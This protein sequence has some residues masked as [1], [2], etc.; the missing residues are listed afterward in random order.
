MRIE[1]PHCSA[2]VRLDEPPDDDT[3]IRCPECRK[4]FAPP[5][6]DDEDDDARPARKGARVAAPPVTRDPVQD[7]VIVGLDGR[8]PDRMRFLVDRPTAA[9]FDEVVPEHQPMPVRLACVV[10]RRGADGVVP[11]RVARLDFLGRADRVVRTIPAA[12]NPED[13]LAALNRDPAKF[14]GQSLEMKVS[15]VP[16]TPRVVQT[17]EY[18]VVFPSTFAPRNLTFTINPGMRQRLVE[19]AGQGLR[20]GMMVPTRITAVV[21]SQPP[22]P[23]GRTVVSISKIEIT[24]DEGRVLRTIE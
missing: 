19:T 15:S 8:R 17:G 24:D 12:P 6:L 2:R 9:E 10:G 20:P 23:G 21:P 3:P 14:A 11:V 4:K 1:C 5:D 22:P 18:A 13:K 7:L 16:L